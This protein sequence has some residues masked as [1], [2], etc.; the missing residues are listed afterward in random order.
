MRAPNIPLVLMT[1]IGV[2]VIAL[3][4]AKAGATSFND[5]VAH[6]TNS[7]MLHDDGTIP[8]WGG[9]T[10]TTWKMR[11]M[12]MIRTGVAALLVS[13]V[14]YGS[15]S[16]DLARAHWHMDQWRPGWRR[17]TSTATAPDQW[18][19][20]DASVWEQE[21]GQLLAGE[22]VAALLGASVLGAAY[23]LGA[24]E[25]R[26]G[27]GVLASIS[28]SVVLMYA[29]P[30][31]VALAINRA[32]RAVLVRRGVPVRPDADTRVVVTTFAVL[33]AT[34]LLA[35]LGAGVATMV[36]IYASSHLLL[37]EL[38]GRDRRR[39]RRHARGGTDI[40]SN[41]RHD[42][43]TYTGVRERGMQLARAALAS[44]VDPSKE[45]EDGGARAPD[46]PSS[47]SPS[48]LM[49]WAQG[50]DWRA[51]H[52]QP[53]LARLCAELV[54]YLA[55]PDASVP[56]RVRVGLED[57][58]PPTSAAGGY[59]SKPVNGVVLTGS[60]S[61][62]PVREDDFGSDPLRELGH[63]V[64]SRMRYTARTSFVAPDRVTMKRIDDVIVN[65]YMPDESVISKMMDVVHE[66]GDSMVAG[67][68]G[69]APPGSPT[70]RLVMVIREGTPDN[71]GAEVASFRDDPLRSGF[72]D[73]HGDRGRGILHPPLGDAF[74]VEPKEEGSST[75][76]GTGYDTTTPPPA[77]DGARYPAHRRRLLDR[78]RVYA[79]AIGAVPLYMLC[80]YVATQ[81][82]SI[83]LSAV[84]TGNWATT[85]M[86]L[87]TPED[88][89]AA[90]LIVRWSQPTALK[91]ATSGQVISALTV[92]FFGGGRVPDRDEFV[93]GIVGGGVT[94]TAM[95][96]CIGIAVAAASPSLM[97][98]PSEA[99]AVALVGSATY[100]VAL[101][102]P[103]RDVRRTVRR[104]HGTDTLVATLVAT[105][106][107]LQGFHAAVDPVVQVGGTTPG[108]GMT[109]L[110]QPR[111]GIGED[112]IDRVRIFLVTPRASVE[113]IEAATQ[114]VTLIHRGTP[115]S[116]GRFRSA[117][118]DPESADGA[119][120]DVA[121]TLSV[122][123][124][125]SISP[126]IPVDDIDISRLTPKGDAT[127]LCLFPPSLT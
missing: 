63:F 105:I 1:I 64:R 27:D 88:N 5:I 29:S 96:T 74:T 118:T 62:N 21:R 110:S 80:V 86:P 71:R 97:A 7:R 116:L 87:P 16:R 90:S 103:W 38:T 115:L 106:H 43:L 108:G 109:V 78:V 55:T 25:L 57:L 53:V 28:A 22:G 98:L 99:S 127:L 14:A 77:T 37:P 101:E 89:H 36:I 91:L 13:V 46:E 59:P 117:T 2:R 56:D 107:R 124:E 95:S 126:D 112:Q 49:A 10:T 18:R 41:P 93:H 120:D 11:H 51:S 102:L 45:G 24:G 26:D 20:L 48:E 69:G 42:R 17:A 113:T 72:C 92:D 123:H 15:I 8:G 122:V 54:A 94:R 85:P 76:V 32:Y 79:T 39:R 82:L 3:I 121:V 65:A 23:S 100:P 35:A 31:R 19:G 84:G 61:P 9:A 104:Y 67:L 33:E 30:L 6:F 114:G 70:P 68:I 12:R 119:D 81:V 83:V 75:T 50:T 40:A 52:S 34:R 4:M 47:Q 58:L 60:R 73:G 44:L 111:A 125:V 66:Q